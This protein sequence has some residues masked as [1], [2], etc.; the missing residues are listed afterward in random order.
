MLIAKAHLAH[1]ALHPDDDDWTPT[2]GWLDGFKNRYDIR[3]VKQAGE[4]RSADVDGARAY[5]HAIRN[6]LRDTGKI[7]Y[8]YLV[9]LHAHLS[10]DRY[11]NRPI[12]DGSQDK[13]MIVLCT[14]SRQILT[15]CTTRTRP[16]SY[17]ASSLRR[18]WLRRRRSKQRRASRPARIALQLW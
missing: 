13:Y 18:R 2:S 10:Y 12:V 14:R 17:I 3:C 11:D 6:L 1:R 16:A 8:E 4:S 5:I 9:P 15:S 7:S